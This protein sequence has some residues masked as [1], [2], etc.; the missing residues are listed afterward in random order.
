MNWNFIFGC[1]AL[2]AGF[3]KAVRDVIDH[4]KD[5]GFLLQRIIPWDWFWN[6]NGKDVEFNG[7]KVWALDGWHI[8]EMLT[9]LAIG[10]GI[11][12]ATQLTAPL[13]GLFFILL[14][15]CNFFLWYKW[16]FPFRAKVN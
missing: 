6:K 14:S 16:I 2:L 7:V 10:V 5:H 4:K 15:G 13:T 12:A 9:W 11:A 8:F 1:A 3:F